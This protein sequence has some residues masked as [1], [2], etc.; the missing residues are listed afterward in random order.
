MPP[1]KHTGDDFEEVIRQGTRRCPPEGECHESKIIGHPTEY[2]LEMLRFVEGS[3]IPV[4]GE[5]RDTESGRHG[6]GVWR[7]FELTSSV[8]ENWIQLHISIWSALRLSLQVTRSW[9]RLLSLGLA[10]IAAI[11]ALHRA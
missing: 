1:R 6:P 7:P 8:D 2:Y 5:A 11:A 10:L 9:R 3:L 4:D